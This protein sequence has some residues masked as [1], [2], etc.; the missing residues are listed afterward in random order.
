MR[1]IRDYANIKR[2]RGK[3]RKN[4]EKSPTDHSFNRFSI[5]QALSYVHYYKIR[6]KTED[7]TLSI[8]FSKQNFN[9]LEW[10]EEQGYI[11]R[12]R[13]DGIYTVEGISFVRVQF[14]IT[15][16]LDKESERWLSSLTNHLKEDAAER[17]VESSDGLKEHNEKILAEVVVNTLVS[18]NGFLFEQ[19]KKKGDRNM[20]LMELMK[21]EVD[22]YA[23]E[24][25]DKKVRE[26]D[27]RNARL[28]INQGNDNAYIKVFTDLSDEEID[29]L[30]KK[31]KA[32]AVGTES[33]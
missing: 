6:N 1:K 7:V 16:E 24:Y 10:V 22:E 9:L 31:E 29:E 27:V 15:E 32:G 17:V 21:P 3:C 5:D 18:A 11:C 19:I 12:K 23:D 25:A 30:R 20:T 26:R 2:E 4:K 13:H 8:V 14:I 28:M 33:L